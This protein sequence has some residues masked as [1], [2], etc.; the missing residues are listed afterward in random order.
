MKVFFVLGGAVYLT[1]LGA[2]IYEKTSPQKRRI[3][4]AYYPEYGVLCF[5]YNHNS[6]SCLHVG[7][8]QR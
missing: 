4:E 2:L 5:I 8:L 3:H 1:L 6:I 7:V